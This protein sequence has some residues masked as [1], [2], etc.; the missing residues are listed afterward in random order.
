MCTCYMNFDLYQANNVQIFVDFTEGTTFWNRQSK[1]RRILYVPQSKT[2]NIY[3]S[4]HETRSAYFHLHNFYFYFTISIITCSC[5]K[6][7]RSKTFFYR[8][9]FWNDLLTHDFLSLYF[10]NYCYRY[11]CDARSQNTPDSSAVNLGFRCA[12]D[13]L[14]SYLN[15]INLVQEEVL[16]DEDNIIKE[17]LWPKY[18]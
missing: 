16:L 17:E 6:K 2:N 12:S 9:C 13:T 5:K 7:N 3:Y 11:R 15:D 14:P 8:T 18:C 1:E 4:R 10:Q